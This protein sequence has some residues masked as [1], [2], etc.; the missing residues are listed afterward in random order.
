MLEDRYGLSFDA[1]F[2]QVDTAFMLD[3]GIRIEATLRLEAKHPIEIQPCRD[4]TMQVRGLSGQD[5]KALVVEGQIAL[6]NLIGLGQGRRSGQTQFLDQ[7]VL[8]GLKQPFD[9]PLGGWRMRMNDFHSQLTHGPLKLTLRLFP[10][11]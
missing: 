2:D 8:Q 9:T 11:C 4:S 5:A 6:Q 1:V 3:G 7:A 10:P